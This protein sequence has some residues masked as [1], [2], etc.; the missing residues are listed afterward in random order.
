ML[1]PRRGE[2]AGPFKLPEEDAW[3]EGKTCSYCGSLDPD[4]FL[5]RARKGE[6]LGPTD[7]DYK[8]YVGKTDNE[9]FYFQ[10]LGREQR[11]E[12]VRLMN[13]KKLNIGYPGHFYVLPFFVRK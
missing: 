1:C 12:F 7:K 3:G 11:V 9:K 13:E 2:S 6:E 5:D 8:V 10:H 4:V